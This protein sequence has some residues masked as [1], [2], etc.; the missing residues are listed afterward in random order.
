MIR[1]M[2]HIARTWRRDQRGATAVEFAIVMPIMMVCFGAIV[3]GARIYWN[4]QSAVSGVRDAARYLARITDPMVCTGPSTTPVAIPGGAARAQD[5][6][7]R[8]VGTGATN[9]FPAAVTVTDVQARYTCPDLNLRSDPTAIAEV[10][11]T[12]TV[13]LPFSAVFEFFGNRSNTEMVSIV[14][15][16]SRIYGL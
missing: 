4:Y 9:L 8:N 16:Q 15:D 11:A 2:L 6:I 5:I 12:L 13:Q 7:A 14:S 1:R 3:E 10:R